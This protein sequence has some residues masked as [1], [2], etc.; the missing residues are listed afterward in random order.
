VWLLAFSKQT[1]THA[2]SATSCRLVFRD[3]AR[4]VILKYPQ[5]ALVD[6]ERS[7][8]VARR[9]SSGFEVFDQLLLGVDNLSAPHHV[10]D[11]HFTAALRHVTELT[12][13]RSP[14]QFPKRAISYSKRESDHAPAN[15]T[16]LSVDLDQPGPTTS[17]G[18][19]AFSKPWIGRR[20]SSKIV[21]PRDSGIDAHQYLSCLS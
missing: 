17:I 15:N 12:L 6:I 9:P 3:D 21:E 5:T 20:S 7:L 16:R 11:R 19:G 10:A 4:Q 1:R 18:A 8:G 14:A 2:N 13:S